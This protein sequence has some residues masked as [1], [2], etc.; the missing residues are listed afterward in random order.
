MPTD[1]KD[2]GEPRHLFIY[3]FQRY[4]T[5]THATTSCNVYTTHTGKKN[6][7][8][9]HFLQMLNLFLLFSLLVFSFLPHSLS[10]VRY[11]YFYLFAS[12]ALVILR[13][14]FAYLLGKKMAYLLV[15][16]FLFLS[17]KKIEVALPLVFLLR[18]WRPCLVR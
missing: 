13:I 9:P 18:G 15:V 2:H 1:L 8:G 4:I 16:S 3:G 7:T 11:C 17:L 5:C 12:L 6:E 10:C 14:F